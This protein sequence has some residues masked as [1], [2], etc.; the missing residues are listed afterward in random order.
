MREPFDLDAYDVLWNSPSS[1]AGESMPCGGGDVG[2]NVWV[3]NG[4]LLIYLARS[5]TFDEL[6]RMPKLG[7]LRV[8]LSPNV[9]LNPQSFRQQLKLREGFVQIEAEKEGLRATIDIWVDVHRPVVHVEVK[10]NAPTELVVAYE[11]WRLTERPFAKAEVH[12]A[13]SWAG[14]RSRAS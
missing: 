4:D 5:G 7:R 2:L 13:R 1:N 9:L 12:A 8:T 14:A 3:E 10:S 6:N 11:S